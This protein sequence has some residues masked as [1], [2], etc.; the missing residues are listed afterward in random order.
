VTH[1]VRSYNFSSYFYIEMSAPNPKLS[2]TRMLKAG[3]G[4]PEDEVCFCH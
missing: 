4:S 1:K 2:E 3:I